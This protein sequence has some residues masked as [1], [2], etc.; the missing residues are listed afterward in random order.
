MK[1]LDEIIISDLLVRGIVGIKEEERFKEQDIL[2]NISLYADLKK[3][4][5]SDKIE[6]TVDYKQI[7]DGVVEI[8]RQSEYYLVE[9]LAQRIADYCLEPD[10]VEKVR[11]NVQKPGA[12]RFARSV[13]FTI[14]RT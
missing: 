6:D 11:I 2:V 12:L 3:A 14:T 8:I 1:H 5:D 10:L 13:G 4:C 9:R 7:K